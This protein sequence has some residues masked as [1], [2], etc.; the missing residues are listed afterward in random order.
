MIVRPRIYSNI[1]SNSIAQPPGGFG[2]RTHPVT[3]KVNT[4]HD[5]VD[6]ATPVGTLV[7]AARGVK[8]V[9]GS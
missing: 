1:L 8:G 6:I 4:Q 5:G 7:N 3:G 9:K 2:L